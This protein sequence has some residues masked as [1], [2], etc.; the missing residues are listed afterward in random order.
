[1]IHVFRLARY[2]DV[3]LCPLPGYCGSPEGKCSPS[4]YEYPKRAA[5]PRSF[6]LGPRNLCAFAL[7]LV[8]RYHAKTARKGVIVFKLT[9]LLPT[10]N[11]ARRLRG[12]F[13]QSGYRET[14]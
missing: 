10:Q 11:Q 12:M 13:K 2:R 3:S 8:A 9:P 7:V 4:Y 14:G 1:M 6:P 5:S